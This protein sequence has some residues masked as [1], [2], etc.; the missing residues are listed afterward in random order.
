MN[1]LRNSRSVFS[2]LMAL[3]QYCNPGQPRLAPR[4]RS[5]VLDSI[6]GLF[7]HTAK[8][9]ASC[10]TPSL[11]A[12]VPRSQPSIHRARSWYRDPW[13]VAG[14]CGAAVLL[15]YAM[16]F[17][18]CAA[19]SHT[20]TVPYTNRTH[21]V[22]F[23]PKLERKLGNEDFVELKKERSKDILGPSDPKTVRVRHIASDIIRGIQELFPADG[24]GDDDAKQGKAAVRSQTGHL[25]DLQWEV[26][27]IRDNRANACSLGGGKIVVFT[28]LLN[29]LETDAEIAAVI[30]HE[31]AHAVARHSMELAMLTPP[32]LNELLPFSRR[33]ELEADLIGM[34]ILAA[35]GFD[36]RV[37]PEIHQK[38]E[39]TV[40][41]DYIGSHPSCKKRSQVLSRGDAMKEAMELYYKQVCS[42]KGANRRFPYGG[43]ISD[44]L[45]S[46]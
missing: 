8:P 3:R 42:G 23:S 15:P 27:V 2:R 17:T 43:K 46:K 24:L 38:R 11:P 32:I 18:A 22:M 44:T 13:K 10:L 45:M 36:P 34:M 6:R 19:V 14:A 37:A 20:E 29:F 26:I 39:S 40:L 41:D 5:H 1:C 21:R 35:A 25:D 30:A 16:V 28:G 9:A 31:A 33:T 4:S 7:F 12:A